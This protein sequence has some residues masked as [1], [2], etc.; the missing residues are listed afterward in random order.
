MNDQSPE[1]KARLQELLANLFDGTLSDEERVQLNETLRGNAAAQDEY[2]RF[3]GVHALL[4][5]DLGHNPLLLLPRVRPAE[6]LKFATDAGGTQPMV[7]RALTNGRRTFSNWIHK[8]Y[9]SHSWRLAGAS[10][11]CAAS[12]A[13]VCWSISLQSQFPARTSTLAVSGTST[14]AAPISIA[15]DIDIESRAVAVLGQASRA[16]WS[17]TA[18]AVSKGASLRPGKFELKQG[19]V[20]LEF[21]SGASVI[22][23]APAEFELISPNRMAC[24]LGKIRTHVPNQAIGFTVETPKIA[25]VDLGTEFTVH[26]SRDGQSQFQV[27]EGEVDLHREHAETDPALQKLVAGEAVQATADGQLKALEVPRVSVVGTQQVLQMARDASHE[28]F[29]AWKH[30]SEQ[31]RSRSDVIF[32]FGF[33]NQQPWDRVLQNEGPN[34][35]ESLNGA[36]VGCQ[37]T[38][39]RWDEKKALEFKRTTDRVRINVPGEYDSL[40]YSAW[41]R[42]EGLDRWLSS[43]LLTDGHQLGEVHWQ[44]TDTGQLMLGVKAEPHESHDFYS[45]SVLGPKDLGR[46]M[47]LA[48]VYDG[49]QGIVYHY[50]DGQEVSSERI[51]IPTKLRIG[52]AEI[53]NWVPQD[54]REYRI[55]SLNG[56]I[57]E[58][59]LFSEPLSADEI[60]AIYESGKP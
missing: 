31:I 15:E 43:L 1:W 6:S 54:L 25:A 60:K 50:L 36:I 39:G 47:H 16:V 38:T 20:Q 30:H 35:A 4:H 23:E 24:D 18:L 17:D 7:G 33:D 51:K 34:K 21:M 49:K 27:I 10:A 45:P 37:W 14:T 8:K 58:F 59:A 2:R 57:D 56:R 11:M 48:C 32:Y 46:W 5:L 9:E 19:V 13:F 41:F 29:Q 52:A 53:G 3:V 22:I 40:T 26:V 28:R 12:L 55:R 44:M 42:I